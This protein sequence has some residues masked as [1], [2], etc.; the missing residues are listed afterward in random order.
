MAGSPCFHICLCRTGQV[1]VF[2]GLLRRRGC[3]GLPVENVRIVPRD[4]GRG[5]R[6]R[7]HTAPGAGITVVDDR[8]SGGESARVTVR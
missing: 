8:S 1:L 7:R 2:Y 3:P 6:S 4:D 5:G